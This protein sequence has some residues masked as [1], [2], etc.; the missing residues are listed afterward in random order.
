[1]IQSPDDDTF[2]DP[3]G[4]LPPALVKAM[5]DPFDY[6][7]GLRDGQVIRFYE[8]EMQKGGQWIKLIAFGEGDHD[9]SMEMSNTSYSFPRGVYVRLSDITWVADAPH[10]S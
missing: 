8:A 7:L 3:T 4:K 10:G 6:A 5:H 2:D 1:M 9:S